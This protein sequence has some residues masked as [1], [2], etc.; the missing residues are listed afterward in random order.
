MYSIVLFI[1]HRIC[2]PIYICGSVRDIKCTNYHPY[3]HHHPYNTHYTQ[4]TLFSP[5][6]QR[7]STLFKTKPNPNPSNSGC[8]NSLDRDDLLSVQKRCCFFFVLYCS[9]LFIWIRLLN[10]LMTIGWSWLNNEITLTFVTIHKQIQISINLVQL[11]FSECLVRTSVLIFTVTRIL[12]MVIRFKRTYPTVLKWLFGNQRTYISHLWLKFIIQLFV[13]RISKCINCREE[14][15]NGSTH[16]I[17]H[18]VLLNYDTLH[19]TSA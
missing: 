5:Y 14:T 15:T 3:T 7:A 2:R 12:S 18:R 17:H 1:A 13:K 4:K 6:Q 9:I 11:P 16:T 19:I 10:Y 8:E